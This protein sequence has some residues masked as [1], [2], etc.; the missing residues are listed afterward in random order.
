MEKH[1]GVKATNILPKCITAFDYLHQYCQH[2]KMLVNIHRGQGSKEGK[3]GKGL[4]R[5]MGN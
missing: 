3:E 4:E 5:G 1:F 2:K